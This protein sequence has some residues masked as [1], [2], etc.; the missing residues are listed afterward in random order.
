MRKQ[1][2]SFVVPIVLLLALGACSPSQDTSGVTLENGDVVKFT[3]LQT[4]DVHHHV[5]GTGPSA[6][7]GTETDATKGGYSKIARKIQYIKGAKSAA[8]T[9]VILVDCGDFLMGTVYDMS[10]GANPAAINFFKT[11]GYNAITIGNHE[12]DY[13]PAMLA[14]FFNMPYTNGTPSYFGT[15][16]VMSNV[17]VNGQAGI[18]ALQT[19]GVIKDTLILTLENGLKVGILGIMGENAASD[20]PIKD[21]LTFR[22]N[23]DP[24]DDANDIAFLQA[25]V[26]AVRAAGAQVVVVLSHSGITDPNSDTRSGDDIDLAD[27]VT[28]I[29]IIASGHNHER[30][31]NVVTRNGA[32]IICAGSYGE[33][34]AQLDVTFKVGTGITAA[35]LTNNCIGNCDEGDDF[36]EQTTAI[37]DK[38]V[39]AL[40]DNINAALAASSLP[41]VNDIVAYTNSDNVALPEG[42]GETGIGNL[43]A[44]SLRYLLGGAQGNPSMAVVANGVIRNGYA[45]GQQISFADI[46]NT[47][48]LGMTLD[49]ANQNIPGYPLVMVYMDQTSITNLCKLAAMT[50]AAADPAFMSSILYAATHTTGDT[51]L[52]YWTKYYSLLRLKED[53]YLNFSGVRYSYDASYAVSG[54]ALYGATDFS[55]QSAAAI[56]VAALGTNRIPV[57]LD[58]YTALMFLSDDM[59]DLLEAAELSIVPYAAA[60]GSTTISMANWASL[61]LDRDTG[62]A[63]VQEVKEW[64]ALLKFV[65]NPSAQLGLNSQILDSKYG[66]AVMADGEDGSRVNAPVIVIE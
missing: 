62:T 66:S 19:K 45:L 5:V 35:V 33:N 10:L 65:T 41:A 49:T 30:T 29:D 58:L 34:L 27:N 47:L 42:P 40:D 3:L 14:Q 2:L 63:G 51:S 31:D 46:Y 32:R 23:L 55:C 57:V 4:T 8:K 36:H 24:E 38:L 59:Q 39:K 50:I 7:Y 54:V 61:R 56:P 28:G 18:A 13:G 52:A 11:M 1:I 48:P 12:L 20:A 16:V 43:C 17:V 6:T 44:D 22:N 9:P 37:R 53:Y 60:T 26:N 25:K 21:P 64:M 15:P